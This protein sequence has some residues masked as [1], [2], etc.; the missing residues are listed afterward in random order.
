MRKLI[1]LA[2]LMCGITAEAA[3]E[4]KENFETGMPSSAPSSETTAALSS[5]E[6]RIKGVAGKKDNN[7]MRAA[8]SGGGYLVTPVLCQPGRVTVSHR[9]SGSGKQLVVE[10]STDGGSTWTEIG[11]VSV[12][13]STPYATSTF[14]C[15]SAEEER[16][17]LVRF[18]SKSST[19]YIDDISITLNAVSSQP[20]PEP[21]DPTY[22]TEGVPVP[23]K[24]F[25][26]AVKTIFI[27]PDGNDQ[28]GDGTI[29]HPWADLQKAVNVAQPGTHIVCRGGTY[30]Q[31]VQSDGKFTVRIKTNGTEEQPIVIRSYEDEQPV[32]PDFGG[33][34]ISRGSTQLKPR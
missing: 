6:W 16:E 21:E 34:N 29:E 32:F 25:P 22:I 7:S 8:M 15:N 28:T 24:P 33:F 31:K 3:D 4:L 5:G 13:S 27:A 26:T 23:T 2:L 19:I 12:S 30:R 11:T 1:A 20:E 10:K 17:V 18:S 14:K 9:A